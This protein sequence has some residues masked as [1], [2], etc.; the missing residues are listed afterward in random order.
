MGLSSYWTRVIE[1]N[2]ASNIKLLPSRWLPPGNIRMLYLQMKAEQ[3][4]MKV[5]YQTFWKT[6]RHYWGKQLRFLAPST[7]GTCDL[8]CSYKTDFRACRDPQTLF[9]LCKYYKMHLDQVGADRELE[10]YLQV[11]DPLKTSGAA[12]AIHWDP[13]MW[14][15]WHLVFHCFLMKSKSQIRCTMVTGILATSEHSG[16]HGSSQME[17]ASLARPETTEVDADASATPTE[18]SSLLGAWRSSWHFWTFSEHMVASLCMSCIWLLGM[19]CNRNPNMSLCNS[20]WLIY[21]AY[22]SIIKWAP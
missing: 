7:H 5:S 9:E 10:E 13:G 4:G 2:W 6:F 18:D 22:L 14:I 12:L 16:W 21:R 20:D 17:G 3:K 1:S 8:C 15:L 19:Y 11:Q